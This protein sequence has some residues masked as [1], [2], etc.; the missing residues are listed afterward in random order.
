MEGGHRTI[1]KSTLL[2]RIYIECNG[3]NNEWAILRFACVEVVGLYHARISL[4]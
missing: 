3:N 2:E 1:Q 4:T